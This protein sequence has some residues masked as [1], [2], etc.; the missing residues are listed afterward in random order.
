MQIFGADFLFFCW[1]LVV[2]SWYV[3][4]KIENY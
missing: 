4:L 2:G 3:Y 1:G